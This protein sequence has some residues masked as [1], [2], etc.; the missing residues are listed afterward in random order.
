[1]FSYRNVIVRFAA[2]VVLGYIL[3]LLITLMTGELLENFLALLIHYFP[4]L[5]SFFSDFKFLQPYLQ[6]VPSAQSDAAKVQVARAALA[7]R[8]ERA[9]S[10]SSGGVDR[11]N[12]ITDN[13]PQGY[14]S[15]EDDS[16]GS[17]DQPLSRTP[18]LTGAGVP[19][20]TP[21]STPQERLRGMSS[22][23]AN[24]L[25]CATIDMDI[26]SIAESIPAMPLDDASAAY[27][28]YGTAFQRSSVDHI[29][30]YTTGTNPMHGEDSRGDGG[31]GPAGGEAVPTRR[32]DPL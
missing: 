14:G 25:A 3:Y 24:M 2:G 12:S 28:D 10:V 27:P 19:P 1:M 18:S 22:A 20:F 9:S 32:P 5:E 23:A 29:E 31:D 30:Q 26:S 13:R 4:S 15:V 11:R 6:H 16:R 21:S 8:P 17:M 7:G